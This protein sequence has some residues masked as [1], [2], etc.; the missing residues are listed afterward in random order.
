MAESAEYLLTNA[1]VLTMDEELNQY[2]PGAVAISGRQSW[3][4]V[5]TERSVSLLLRKKL[6][7]A[8]GMWSCRD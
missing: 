8:R 4:S 6:S 7:T 3:Q 2:D 5:L 1:I